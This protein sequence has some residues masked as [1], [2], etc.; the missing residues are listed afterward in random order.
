[1]IRKEV[2]TISVKLT[3]RIRQQFSFQVRDE[4][5]NKILKNISNKGI[6]FTGYTI[7]KLQNINMVK[8]VVGPPRSNDPIANSVVREVLRL[9]GVRFQEKKVIQLL[10]VIAGTPGILSAIYNALFRKVSIDAIYQGE[11]NAII[12]SVSNVR[13]ALRILKQNNLIV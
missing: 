11:L 5:L 13:E 4:T 7:T 6:S 2:R 1:M 12:L 3:P 9:L 8:I 10:G